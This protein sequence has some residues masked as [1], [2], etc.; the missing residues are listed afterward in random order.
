MLKIRRPLTLMLTT[1]VVAM[2]I[3]SCTIVKIGKEESGEG[4]EYSTWTKTGTGF[5]ASKYVEE[6]WEDKMISTYESEAVDYMTL[7]NA[8]SE[9]RAAKSEEYGLLRQSGEPFYIFK[10]RGTAR[11]LDLDD[12]SRVGVI[13]IDHDLDGKADAVIQVGP[14]FKGTTL[15]DSAEF[16]RFTD[17]GN[18]LQF[19]DLA[20]ELNMR[21][22]A[23]SIDSLDF[24]DIV[25]KTIEYLGAFRLE[26]E[27]ALEDVIISPLTLSVVE[28]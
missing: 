4:D 10:V 7:M 5:Q 25:G 23:D 17:V 11:I 3:S 20:K 19:A 1:L 9:D 6:I 22:K 15:R 16:I 27:Q 2:L 28:E 21:M 18:Q 8:L 24:T 12:S 14:V 26:T 13:H